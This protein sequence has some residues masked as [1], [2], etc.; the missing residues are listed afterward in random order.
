MKTSWSAGGSSPVSSLRRNTTQ[1]RT[2]VSGWN[3]FLWQLRT[4]SSCAL[5][6]SSSRAGRYVAVSRKLFGMTIPEVT[7]GREPVQAALEEQ[8]LR[9]HTVEAVGHRVA[10]EDRRVGD[11]ALVVAGE[12]GI[13]EDQG[14][15]A[16]PAPLA[17][18]VV[19]RVVR[20]E[21]VAARHARV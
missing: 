9:R 12:R 5:R 11:E 13:G 18:P 3:V 14:R 8:H 7:A 1:V 19:E 20:A 6:N 21:A 15:H 16:A 2:P 4:A 10:A 17:D